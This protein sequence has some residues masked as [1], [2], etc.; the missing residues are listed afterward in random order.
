MSEKAKAR[1]S[2]QA[3]VQ[4]RVNAIDT[5]LRPHDRLAGGA[6]VQGDAQG[7]G[8]KQQVSPHRPKRRRNES[9]YTEGVT[10]GAGSHCHQMRFPADLDELKA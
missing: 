8:V 3:N 1:G 4:K 9:E 6:F 2:R 10:L 7:L 5:L